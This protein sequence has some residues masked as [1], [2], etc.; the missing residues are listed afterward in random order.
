MGHGAVGVIANPMAG[1]DVRRIVAAASVFPNAEKARM[2]QRLLAGLGAAGVGRVLLSTDAGG[3][4]AAVLR[5]LGPSGG[6][7][8]WPEVRFVELPELTE[9]AS[10]TVALVEAMLAAGVDAIVC[11]GGDGTARVAAGACRGTPLLALSTGTNNAYPRVREATVAGLAVGLVATGALPADEATVQDPWLVVHSR[12]GTEHALVDVCRTT[13]S[14][15]GSRA[16]WQPERLAELCCAF[17]EADAIGLSSIP[18]LICPVGRDAGAGVLMHLVPAKEADVVVRAPIAPGLVADVGIASWRTLRPGEAVP[19]GPGGTVALDGER[20][21][22]LGV[23][24]RATVTFRRDGPIRIE[25]QAALAAAAER[26][27]LRRPLTSSPDA[28][29]SLSSDDLPSSTTHPNHEEA[30]CMP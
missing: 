2:V 5:A 22:E 14:M 21:L 18:G 1:R 8:G 13:A 15:Q 16:L 30:R 17:A 25:P 10:D 11:L 7:P 19:V 20:E 4:S 3:I 23:E 24:E 9:T 26:G 6:R 27:L 12:Q 29:T 28:G